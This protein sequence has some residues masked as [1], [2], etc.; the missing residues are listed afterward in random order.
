MYYGTNREP[1]SATDAGKGFGSERDETG[2]LHRGRCHVRINKG[3]QFGSLGE[4]SFLSRL[5]LGDDR[6]LLQSTAGLAPDA[7]TAEIRDLLG[8]IRPNQAD[9]VVYIH[10]FNT[11][12]EEAAVR[13]AQIGFDLNVPGVMAFF[14]WPSLGSLEKYKEDKDRVE[15][16][17]AALQQFLREMVADAGNGR[18]HLI[19]HSMG[20]LGFADAIRT[21]ESE[22][23]VRFGQIILAAPD[24]SPARFREVAEKYR[25]L[26]ARTTLYVSSR[27]LALE[28]S[29]LIGDEDRIGYMPPVEVVQGID[30]IEVSDIDLTLLGHDY[31]AE[32]DAVLNDIGSLLRTDL[33]P[34]RRSRL[35]P[36][37][38]DHWR[39]NR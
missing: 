28:A 13:A 20:N 14:S 22:S 36:T 1:I 18:V 15:A 31:F 35:L 37:D 34:S 19:V 30:T 24:L 32:A 33:D 3:H 12:F 11:T 21:L 16:S 2:S 25:R 6:V 4:R 26:S 10:G 5:F 39:I 8:R 23:N 17:T 29:E 38:P 9:I 7:F 27:D